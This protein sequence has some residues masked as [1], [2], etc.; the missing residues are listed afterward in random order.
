MEPI[1]LPVAN[2]YLVRF[3]PKRVPHYF[4]DVLVIGGGIAGTRAALA[5]EQCGMQSLILR[6]RKGR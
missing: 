3:D 2:R 4:T 5:V 6:L 1:R